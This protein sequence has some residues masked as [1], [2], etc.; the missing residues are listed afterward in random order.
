MTRILLVEDEKIAALDIQRRLEQLGYQVVAHVTSGEEAIRSVAAL[1][2]DMVLMDIVLDGEMD[3][4]EAAQAIVS[5]YATPVIYLTAHTDENT[6][7]R[8]RETGPFGYI[9]KPPETGALQ[10]T[11]EMAFY[12]HRAEKEM[13]ISEERFRLLFQE[14]LNAFAATARA[15]PWISASSRLILPSRASW[16]SPRTGSSA[17]PDWRFSP[18]SNPSG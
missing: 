11:L 3:G 17:V 5:H 7:R 8:A 4:I 1:S 18:I 12:K 10:S 14:M 16:N 15:S 9:V 6:L 2:P 13:R